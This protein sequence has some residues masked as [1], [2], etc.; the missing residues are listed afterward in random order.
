MY[1]ITH[2][3]GYIDFVGKSVPVNTHSHS[4][5]EGPEFLLKVPLAAVRLG[6][7]WY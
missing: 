6:I 7:I 2:V 4:S 3:G 1:N 5:A